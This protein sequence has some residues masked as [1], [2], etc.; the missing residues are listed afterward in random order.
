MRLVRKAQTPSER[1]DKHTPHLYCLRF[2]TWALERVISVSCL[3]VDSGRRLRA[4]QA[5]RR[6]GTS[7]LAPIAYSDP[8]AIASHRQD[9][10]PEFCSSS[11][12]PTP[13]ALQP[14]QL[15]SAERIPLRPAVLIKAVVPTFPS[16]SPPRTLLPGQRSTPHLHPAPAI[17]LPCTV[18]LLGDL[19][20]V[21]QHP[22]HTTK[23]SLRS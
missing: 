6:P 17:G 14:P 10:K 23:F 15:L 13:S 12:L 18:T 5:R 7:T 19:I 9:I 8:R 11:H 20:G 3:S 22:A 4:G 21:L 2:L 16:I 1:R